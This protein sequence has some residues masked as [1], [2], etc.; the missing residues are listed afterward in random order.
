MHEEYRALNDD[1]MDASEPTDA[2]DDLALWHQLLDEAT[3]ARQAEPVEA[4]DGP[5]GLPY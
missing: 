4:T 3:I 2:A 5:D 1:A